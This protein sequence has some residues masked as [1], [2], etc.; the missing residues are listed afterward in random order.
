MAAAV[1]TVIGITLCFVFNI[2]VTLAG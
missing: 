2:I 1:P